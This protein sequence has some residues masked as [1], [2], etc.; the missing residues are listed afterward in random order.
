MS[1]LLREIFEV[2]ASLLVSPVPE[3]GMPGGK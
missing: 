3:Y 1:L 2:A